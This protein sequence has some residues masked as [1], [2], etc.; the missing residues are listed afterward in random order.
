MDIELLKNNEIIN[1]SYIL[2]YTNESP[3]NILI[4]CHITKQALLHLFSCKLCDKN[5][6]NFIT[7]YIEYKNIGH[8]CC[9]YENKIYQSFGS[10]YYLT[11][12]PIDISINILI[13][14]IKKYIHLFYP[15]EYIKAD[16][17]DNI[18]TKIKY[19]YTSSSYYDIFDKLKKLKKIHLNNMV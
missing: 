5:T 6:A 14:N 16:I 17:P 10:Y 11:I 9:I 18:Y 15:D 7:L 13:R 8:S 4:T 19:Y 3:D 12:T 1:K 2:N